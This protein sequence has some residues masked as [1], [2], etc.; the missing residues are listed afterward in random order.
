MSAPAAADPIRFDPRHRPLFATAEWGV[1]LHRNQT[2][3][4]RCIVHLRTRAIDDPLALTAAERDA[5]WTEV[6]PRLAHGLSGAF[7]PDRLNYA[8][9]AN[10]TH[11]V[12]W[13]V[14]PRYE[15]EPIRWFGGVMFRDS[16]PG[17]IFRSRKRGRVS[18]D[19]LEVIAA[20]LVAHLPHG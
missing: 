5:L 4:G 3:L 16:R 10:R 13:H 7:A 8:H 6:L 12:H 17:R 15:A 18:P 2:H 1:L 19:V 20:E 14:V 9:L 11:H